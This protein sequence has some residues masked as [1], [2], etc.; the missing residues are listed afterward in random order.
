MVDNCKRRKG[1][2]TELQT[3]PQSNPS[4]TVKAKMQN[5][6][7]SI[8]GWYDQAKENDHTMTQGYINLKRQLELMSAGRTKASK[9]NQ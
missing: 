6:V 9:W 2:T 5:L 3:M 4:M 1:S 7:T 8:D